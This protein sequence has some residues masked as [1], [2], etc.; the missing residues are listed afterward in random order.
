MWGAV[1]VAVLCIRETGDAHVILK[2]FPCGQKSRPLSIVAHKDL[3][4]SPVQWEELLLRITLN[5]SSPLTRN[6]NFCIQAENY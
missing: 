6:L 5:S 4:F 1:C 2:S 3:V